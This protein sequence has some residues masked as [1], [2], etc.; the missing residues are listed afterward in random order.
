M[1]DKM[2]GFEDA[3]EED[4]ATLLE[5]SFKKNESGKLIEGKI[6]AIN[7]EQV[8]IDV[9]EKV[10]GK[11][12]ISEI[13]APSGELM[14]AV[15][16][17]IPLIFNGFK[18]ERPMISHK[19]AMKA[20]KQKEFA[21]QSAD[22]ETREIV[23]KGKVVKENKGGYIV[24]GDNGAEFFMPRSQSGF[25]KEEKAIGKSVTA[26][27]IKVDT[28]ENS[29]LIS[30]IKLIREK[31]KA[32]K[33]A[34]NDMLEAKEAVQ[35]TIKSIASFGIFVEASGVDGLVRYDEISF[36][37]PVNPVN[38]FT[39][40]ETVMVKAISYDKDKNRVAFSI[41]A[42]TND[43]WDEI[44]DELEEG[45]TVKAV[46]SNIEDYGAFLDLGND[47]EGFLHISEISWKKNLKH[48]NE[49][50]AIGQ[51]L[52]V[53]I[54]EIDFDKRKLRMSLKK[55]LPKPFDTF[56]QKHKVGD[57]V[58]A[59]VL[60]ITDF[61]AFLDI[62][63][64]EGLLHN[65]DA[66]WSRDFKCKDS[67]KSGET[68]NVKII[69]IDSEKE[70]VSLSLKELS[71]SPIAEFSKKHRVGD[72]IT[73]TIRDVKEFGVFVELGANVDGLI[74][75]DELYPRK[76]EEMSKGEQIECVIVN[77][78]NETGKIRLS[79]KRLQREKE[80]E[81]VKKFNDQSDDRS[82]SNSLKDKLGS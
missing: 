53:E 15:G 80:R 16:D 60:N 70:K 62:G 58:S 69:K 38:S 56:K 46:V 54:T 71:D 66:S 14:F 81:A 67:L 9:N 73:G 49:V 47:I 30:R 21:E 1:M 82:F 6:V 61:G 64:I 8:T 52:T 78:S 34:I 63:D 10:E 18:N 11:I 27:V 59:K 4:F 42:A 77:I 20:A 31:Q 26:V 33:D 23:V 19:S 40:G 2:I 17:K 12:N 65:E 57:V 76:K 68:L 32:K 7:N 75:N 25:K 28:A 39:V 48:P 3:G 43:P 50:L 51:E 36:K 29:I 41:K 55:L 37:G 45:D 5:Q 13:T 79:I 44:R 74:P 22:F 24:E 72:T 35:A